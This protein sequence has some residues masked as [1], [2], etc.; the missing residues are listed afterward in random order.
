MKMNDVLLV[1][2]LWQ[3]N[4]CHPRQQIRLDSKRSKVCKL[5]KQVLYPRSHLC[6]R[7]PFRRQ[8]Y[9]GKWTS[10]WKRL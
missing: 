4:K 10:K 8:L 1:Y 5:E 7:H 6:H 3:Y 2:L 9:Y